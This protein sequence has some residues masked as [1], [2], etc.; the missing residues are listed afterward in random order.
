MKK[1]IPFISPFICGLFG[2]VLLTC[3][4]YVLSIMTSPFANPEETPFLACNF[5]ISLI[6]I[7]VIIAT[8]VINIIYLINL[9]NK[10]KTKIITIAEICVGMVFL[11]IFWNLGNFIFNEL[12]H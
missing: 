11:F 6:S 8:V 9:D 5:F 10:K 4:L 7:F 2:G 1:W 12:Y 3:G